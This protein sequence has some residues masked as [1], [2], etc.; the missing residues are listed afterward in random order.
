MVNFAEISLSHLSIDVF[1]V[2]V[3]RSRRYSSTG[4]KIAVAIPYFAT[5]CLY[6]D[7]RDI[8]RRPVA[9]HHHDAG[10]GHVVSLAVELEIEADAARPVNADVLI[11][12]RPADLRAAA[13]VA[14]VQNDR[15][16]HDRAGVNLRR[17][18]PE[19]NS[20]P[21]RPTECSRP[22]RW[23]RWPTPRRFFVIESEL[24]RRVGKAAGA[25]R[26]LPVV[27]IQRRLDGAQIHVGFVISVDGPDVAPVRPASGRLAGNL[28]GLEIVGVYRAR[29]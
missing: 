17:R 5:S 24:R 7:R 11:E 15:I 1:P 19:R 9:F 22:T 3:P 6:V 8:H 14:V 21:F 29:A 25:Q 12:N 10:L 28:V 26:P 23:N 13:D 4:A 16:L 2:C 18:A 27:E 20:S